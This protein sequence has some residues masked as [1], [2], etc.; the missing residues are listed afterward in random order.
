MKNIVLL[1]TLLVVP[2]SS[3]A[4]C[5]GSDSFHTCN[6]NSGNTYS[7]QTIG[8]TTYVNGYN[9]RTGSNWS[10]ESMHI[11][12]T[13]YTNGRA[14]NGNSWDMTTQRIGDT[15]F[16]NGRNSQGNYFSKTCN[17]FGCY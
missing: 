1:F 9:S 15:T 13:T 11:G 6:D 3:F 7:I 14:A 2:V 4:A 5:Y 16:M 17:Q 8:D 12:N 10:Q